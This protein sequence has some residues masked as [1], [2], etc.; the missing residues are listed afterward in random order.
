MAVQSTL[1]KK[2]PLEK[3]DFERLHS[4]LFCYLVLTFLL[5]MDYYGYYD[6]KG[7]L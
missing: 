4:C 2:S 5:T 3:A 6:N 1:A 7:S